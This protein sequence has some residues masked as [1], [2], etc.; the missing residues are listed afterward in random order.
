MEAV[1]KEPIS[2][3]KAALLHGVPPTTLKDRLSG[4]VA[5]STKPGPVKYLNDEEDCALSDHLIKAAKAGYGKT[6]GQVK[7]IV[8][9]VVREKKLL[10]SDQVSDGWWRRFMEQQPHLSLHFQLLT[11]VW[12]L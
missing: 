6:Q 8:E 4:R 12:T 10:R 1:R 3:N 7:V 5:H 11:S 9:N 2:I